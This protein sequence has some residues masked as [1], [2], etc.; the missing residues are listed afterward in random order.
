MSVLALAA[1]ASDEAAVVEN[2][3]PPA[4]APSTPVPPQQT[5]TA[6]PGSV[7]DF[8]ETAGDRVFFDYDSFTL[9]S[10]AQSTL[11]R[12]ASWLNQY[13]AVTIQVHGNADERGTREYNLALA[14]RRANSVRDY[15]VSAGV[16]GSRIETISNGEESPVCSASTEDCWALN[17]N[18]T[19]VIV[20][21]ATS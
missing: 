7:E 4:A 9:R 10:D 5:V 1:C 19:T 13:S 14:A 3:P 21:G 15:L 16:A 17:R 6:I 12:Q 11:D 20:S 8:Q 2:V 18:G